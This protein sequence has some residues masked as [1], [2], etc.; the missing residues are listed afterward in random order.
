M[1]LD[2]AGGIILAIIVIIIGVR[3]IWWSIKKT[4]ALAIT[5]ILFAL[6]VGAALVTWWV[7]FAG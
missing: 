7:L 4:I 2:I 3:L 5:A 1:T 6:V